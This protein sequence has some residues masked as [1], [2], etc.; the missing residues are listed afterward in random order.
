[1]QPELME[2]NQ[3]LDALTAQVA[4]LTE[5]AQAAERSRAE[6]EELVYDVMP[7]AKDALNLAT[8]HL[9][10]VEEYVRLD[11]L[12][13]MLK[14]LVR[15]G[16][17]LEALLD[18]L[19]AVF[20][21]VETV[22]PI[23]LEA[24]TKATTM[25]D[26]LERKGYFAFGESGL[27]L[28]D[29]VVTSFTKEDVDRLGD[30]VVL[31]LNTVKDMTQPEMLTFVRNTLAASEKALE[32]PVNTSLGALL[33]QLRDPQVRRGLALTLRILKTVGAQSAAE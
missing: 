9:Q 27:R 6:R 1:M 15:H 10:D 11:D 29:N 30:N 3:K 25:M 4:Y 2:L 19:D 13:R 28:V 32:E 24:V 18:Q 31:L 33:S 7:I 22:N 16:P 21:L 17:Q 23:A 26:E 14:K 20:D 12:L 8:V 5:Q